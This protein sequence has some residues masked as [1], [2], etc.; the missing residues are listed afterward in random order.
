M[1]N[2]Y[3]IQKAFYRYIQHEEAV[4]AIEYALIASLIAIAIITAVTLIGTNVSAAFNTIS[5]A[6]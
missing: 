5:A 4:T 2:L 3:M 1:K 6:L